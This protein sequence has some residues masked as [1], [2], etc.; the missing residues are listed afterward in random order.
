[1]V[2]QYSR[3]IHS[4]DSLGMTYNSRCPASDAMTVQLPSIDW[5][6]SCCWNLGTMQWYLSMQQK[7]SHCSM[8]LIPWS[9]VVVVISWKFRN[10]FLIFVRS[11]PSWGIIEFTRRIV[12][13]KENKTAPEYN[14]ESDDERLALKKRLGS[15]NALGVHTL[16]EFWNVMD[17]CRTLP[18]QASCTRRT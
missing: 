15:L 1:M 17:N 9:L 12:F 18:G 2:Q 14:C 7:A 11:N 13:E 16:D 5:N 4:C 6:V 3:Y 8:T 10:L